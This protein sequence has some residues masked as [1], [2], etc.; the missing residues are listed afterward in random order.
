MKWV[1]ILLHCNLNNK[2]CRDIRKHVERFTYSEVDEN[3]ILVAFEDIFGN[4]EKN[5]GNLQKNKKKCSG[6]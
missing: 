3:L 5:A 4:K 6:L 1:F 2:I